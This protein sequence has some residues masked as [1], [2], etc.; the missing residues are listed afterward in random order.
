MKPIR[1]FVALGGVSLAGCFSARPSASDNFMLLSSRNS[2]EA[3]IRACD[4]VKFATFLR[5]EAR[6]YWNQIYDDR[7]IICTKAFH[8]G[9]IAGFVDYVESGGTGEPP[10][11]PPFRYRLMPYRT[12]DGGTAVEDWYSGFRQGSAVAKQ[13][14]LREFNVVPLP[15]APVPFDPTPPLATNQ[16]VNPRTTSGSPWDQP[17]NLPFP[18]NLP[19]PRPVNPE[20]DLPAPGKILPNSEPKL[21]ELKLPEVNNDDRGENN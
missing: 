19:Q 10:Y 2:V 16:P 5:S 21:P 8:E 4:E 18:S 6:R 11:L 14:G 7:G 15:G 1:Y 13:S 17:G 20:K 9:F 3:P 12:P